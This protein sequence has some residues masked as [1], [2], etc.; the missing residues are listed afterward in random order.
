MSGR[1]FW[2]VFKWVLYREGNERTGGIQPSWVDIT[3]AAGPIL[4][5]PGCETKKV[6]F[7]SNFQDF[8]EAQKI[9]VLHVT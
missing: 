6:V 5:K 8:N 3:G 2:A 7:W 4:L 9:K 1:D